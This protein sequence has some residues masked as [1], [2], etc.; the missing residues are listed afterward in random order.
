MKA[1]RNSTRRMRANQN[2][3]DIFNQYTGNAVK[4][5]LQLK[6]KNLK[7]ELNNQR[8]FVGVRDQG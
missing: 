3:G 8:S 2:A 6:G 1:I 7:Y 4:I 5:R